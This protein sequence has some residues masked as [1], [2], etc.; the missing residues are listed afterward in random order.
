[1]E[2]DITTLLKAY[3]TKRNLTQ[4]ELAKRLDLNECQL[5]RWITG[6]QTPSKT[7]AKYVKI[8]LELI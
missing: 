4:R 2:Q 1:M 5:S 8:R 6:V 7:M 3:K